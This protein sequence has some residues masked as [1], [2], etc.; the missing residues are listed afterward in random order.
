M[1]LSIMQ[2][3]MHMTGFIC[4][5]LVL[6][7]VG[8]FCLYWIAFD[9]RMDRRTHGSS[10]NIVYPTRVS[11][12]ERLL[13]SLLSIP[14]MYFCCCAASHCHPPSWKDQDLL[15]W[16]VWIQQHSCPSRHNDKI[17]YFRPYT[18]CPCWAYGRKNI[19]R[20][21]WRRAKGACLARST[22][23][24]DEAKV[25]CLSFHMNQVRSQSDQPEG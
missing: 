13:L 11:I 20:Q 5:R 6:S 8:W 9:V 14:N 23:D 7:V 21:L 19:F 12:G 1:G 25:Q 17:L 22:R 2:Y 10:E 15:D 3:F 16:N 18:A 4:S 24:L